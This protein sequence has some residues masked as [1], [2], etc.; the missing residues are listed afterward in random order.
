MLYAALCVKFD[1]LV[2]IKQGRNLT[3]TGIKFRPYRFFRCHSSQIRKTIVSFP[4]WHSKTMLPTLIFAVIAA[5]IWP[6]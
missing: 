5:A 4:V 1:N 2:H 6:A 3:P